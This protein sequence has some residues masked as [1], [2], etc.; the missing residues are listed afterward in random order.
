MSM[1]TWAD[2]WNRPEWVEITEEKY[3]Q[4]KNNVEKYEK[5]IER[6]EE[7]LEEQP[8]EDIKEEI[9]RAKEELL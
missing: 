4:L 5:L 2:D 7:I 8:N 9:E 3:N 6:I 1:E